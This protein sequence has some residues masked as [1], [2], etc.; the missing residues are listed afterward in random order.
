MTHHWHNIVDKYGVQKGPLLLVSIQDPT[1]TSRKMPFP[2]VST[3]MYIVPRP[4][5]QHQQLSSPRVKS[6][7]TILSTIPFLLP[8]VHESLV[9]GPSWYDQAR[10]PCSFNYSLK[11]L[12]LLNPLTP[13][14]PT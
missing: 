6:K 2:H 8:L 4:Y 11:Q 13:K 12:G 1:E 5:L 9:Y 7:A 3:N 10:C 14:H